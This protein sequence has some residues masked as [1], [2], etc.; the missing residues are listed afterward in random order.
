VLGDRL[1]DAL[2]DEALDARRAVVGAD[3]QLVAAGAEL[4]FPEDQRLLRKP[5]TPIT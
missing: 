5:S 4:V 2:G 1:A 3:D